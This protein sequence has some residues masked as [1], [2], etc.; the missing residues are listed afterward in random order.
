MFRAAFL[1]CVIS[2]A[3]LMTG[4]W[5]GV[6]RQV[7]ATVLSVRGEVVY[8]MDGRD[9]VRSLTL[10]TN[11]GPGSLLR[12]AGDARAHLE[13]VPGALV[14]ISGNSE[15]KIEELLLRK[16]GNE[17]GAG[18]RKRTARVRLNR[19]S[20]NIVFERRDES[21]LRFTVGTRD[22]TI[23]A[24][25]DCV[26]QVR[27][28]SEKTR[29]TCVYGRAYAWT[30]NPEPSI[31]KAGYFQEWPSGSMTIAAND[32]RGQIDVTEA[33]DARRELEELQ[34]GQLNRPPFWLSRSR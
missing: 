2:S 14:Q 8:Q 20:I 9:R 34:L 5:A 13:L 4:C 19:G 25:G 31:V 32:M 24:D 27:V 6:S 15:L 7:L 26:S 18:M 3:A 22:V 21:E 28:E 23:S 33:L 10:Q 17:T 11:P 1:V 16:D 12:T 30:G 29:L